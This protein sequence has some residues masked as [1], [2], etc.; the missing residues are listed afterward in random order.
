VSEIVMVARQLR[1]GVVLS[2]GASPDRTITA[3]H[4]ADDALVVESVDEDGRDHTERFENDA[5][6]TVRI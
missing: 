5:G 6:V 3:V 4:T 2:C 1:P